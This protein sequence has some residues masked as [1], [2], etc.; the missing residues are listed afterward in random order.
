[1][2]VSGCLC[3]Y[4]SRCVWAC[5]PVCEC[6]GSRS[7]RSWRQPVRVRS[8]GD[9]DGN[10][11]GNVYVASNSIRNAVAAAVTK[12]KTKHQQQNTN[13]SQNGCLDKQRKWKGQRQNKGEKAEGV[14]SR[15]VVEK[16]RL[17]DRLYQ[18]MVSNR[19]AGRQPRTEL[20]RLV[21]AEAAL[22]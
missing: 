22:R 13:N 21:Y 7:W 19:L 8:T 17:T 1:M 9:G 11:N 20:S 6:V 12:T 18:K 5:L 10:G 2:A 3:G 4:T 14:V 16:G 15:G